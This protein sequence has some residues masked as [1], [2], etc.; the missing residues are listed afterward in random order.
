[1]CPSRPLDVG[2]MQQAA[3]LLIGEHDFATFGQPPQGENTVRE[4]VSLRVVFGTRQ[5]DRLIRYQ[6][7]ANA[8]LYRMVR[9]IV[10][11]LVRVGQR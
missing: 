10:G 8:F 1:M 2:A 6:I 5:G 11:A 3:A 9:R 7:E 4:V